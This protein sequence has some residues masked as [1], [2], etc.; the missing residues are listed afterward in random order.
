MCVVVF[1]VSCGRGVL[2]CVG[3]RCVVL[4]CCVVYDMLWC[5][6]GMA[7]VCG[8]VYNGVVCVVVLFCVCI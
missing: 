6:V 7:C 5:I 4:L 3:V 1:F 8:V 2:F